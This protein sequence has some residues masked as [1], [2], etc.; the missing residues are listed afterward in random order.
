MQNS[1]FAMTGN[2]PRTG[3]LPEESF[4]SKK[5]DSL[6]PYRAYPTIAKTLLAP[7]NK[8]PLKPLAKT[9]VGLATNSN[10]DSAHLVLSISRLIAK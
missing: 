10:V 8:I 4:L 3:K 9:I 6:P 2:K 5:Y 1:V 7:E